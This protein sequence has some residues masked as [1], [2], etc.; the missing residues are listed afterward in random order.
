MPVIFSFW[1]N[2]I[3]YA[4]HFWKFRNIVVITSRN[5]DGEYIARVIRRFGYKTARGSSSRG[6]VSALIQLRQD[7][8]AGRDIAFTID[9]PRGPACQVKP[10]PLWLSKKTR[11]PILP[12]HIQPRHFWSLKTWDSF[13]IPKPFSEVLVKIGTPI[14]VPAEADENGLLQCYQKEMEALTR[15]CEG[16]PW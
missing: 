15:Y 1:H 9:G 12:F 2:Q 8:S 14:F 6:A 4:T 16:Y 7:L 13:R 11:N 5:F 3:F 10:G